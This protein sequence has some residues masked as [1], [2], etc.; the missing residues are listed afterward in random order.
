MPQEHLDL[1]AWWTSGPRELRAARHDRAAAASLRRSRRLWHEQ[2]AGAE[3]DR[4]A[5]VQACGTG[6]VQIR[7]E[8]CGTVHAHGP[9]RCGAWRYCL[10]CRG[11]R[12]AEYR[13]RFSLAR[14]RWTRTAGR[15]RRQRERFL[16]LTIPHRSPAADVRRLLDAWE[17]FTRSLRR[18]LRRRWTPQLSYVRVLEL[19]SSDGGHVHLHAW[20]GAAYLPHA[21]LRVLWGRALTSDYVPV[22]PILEVLPELDT[23]AQDE[24][25]EVARWRSRR[26]RSYVPW[27]VLDIRTVT[28]GI[29]TE[30]VKYML[31]MPEGADPLV[32][33]SC[34]EATEGVRV[35]GAALHF[36]LAPV[37]I[38]CDC[39]ETTLVLVRDALATASKQARAPP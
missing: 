13:A 36:W 23:R 29:E 37:R 15:D 16:T 4:P 1:V 27:P 22:R 18:W 2:R 9:A 35:V 38:E 31:K 20:I 28:S 12:A 24:L 7:C 19:T 26:V 25:L 32:V 6:S 33:A 3:R 10:T 5:R 30:L 17:R 11:Q 14:E 34:I 21:V 39:G 8:A